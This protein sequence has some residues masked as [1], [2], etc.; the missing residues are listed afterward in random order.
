MPIEPVAHRGHCGG[1]EWAVCATACPGEVRS[2]DAFL[3]QETQAGVLVAVIDGLGHGDEAA[4]VAGRAVAALRTTA[5]HPLTSS[6]TAC[7]VALRGTRGVVMTLAALD[8]VRFVLTWAAV[9]N[10]DAAV[11]RPGRV[12]G[13]VE[14]WSV[15]LRGGVLGDRLPPLRESTVHLALSDT[16][17][18]ATDGVSPA[19][20]DTVDLSLEAPALAR[21][22]HTGYA[23]GDDDALV[24]VARCAPLTPGTGAAL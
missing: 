14:R 20:L 10:V 22:L 21:E 1:V 19:F 7:H 17:V 24:L 12:P 2:G 9:G 8:P 6:F 18:A 13:A 11:L 5:D 23:T 3:V 15:P 16:F 4:E